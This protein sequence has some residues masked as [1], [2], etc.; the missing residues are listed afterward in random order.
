MLPILKTKTFAY[1]LLVLAVVAGFYM[2]QGKREVTKQLE[3][4]T[5]QLKYI[6]N[7]PVERIVEGP[8]KIIEGK[9]IIKEII[10]EIKADGTEVV[11]ETETITEPVITERGSTVIEK[12]Y[13]DPI[14]E[15]EARKKKNSIFTQYFMDK[16]LGLGFTS[17][18]LGLN[19]GPSVLYNIDRKD[20]KFG[21]ILMYRF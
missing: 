5:K 11:R 7:N 6:M 3:E 8:V 20:L 4:K 9:T 17:D 21:A 12:D 14:G 13:K 19:F 10:R 18:F 15:A 1:S 16:T 2:W